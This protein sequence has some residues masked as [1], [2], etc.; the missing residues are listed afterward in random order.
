MSSE[1]T[2]RVAILATNGFEQVELTVP[3]AV[4]E[5]HGARVEIV[6]PSLG[7]IRGM[8]HQEP[9]KKVSVDWS[10]D[11]A[12]ASQFDALYLPGGLLS[13]DELRQNEAA[14]KFV[15][16]FDFAAKPIAAICHGPWLLVSA[17]LVDGRRLTSWPAIKDDVKNAGAF[18]EDAPVV[19]DGN[20]L[21]SRGPHDLPQFSK[22]IVEHFGLGA[23]RTNPVRSLLPWIIGTAALAALAYAGKRQ[24]DRNATE[25]E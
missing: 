25:N 12:E 14:L 23:A 6:S 10:L 18:W 9:G 7:K 5:Q 8:N 22:A 19:R 16:D 13:P 1:P 4:L 2:A 20:W 15:R 11:E 21:S 3:K 24:L 17:G